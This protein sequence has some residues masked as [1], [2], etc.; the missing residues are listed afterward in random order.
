MNKNEIIEILQDWNFWKKDLEAGNK[1]KRNKGIVE[2]NG[3]V[4]TQ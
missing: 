2:G 3:K 1:S 4:K